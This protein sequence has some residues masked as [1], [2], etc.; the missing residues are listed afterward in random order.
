MTSPD[1]SQL[2]VQNSA[3]Q[4]S[5]DSASNSLP[6]QIAPRRY[7]RVPPDG[8]TPQTRVVV[9]CGWASGKLQYLQKYDTLYRER[10]F[11][12]FYILTDSGP[13]FNTS[14]TAKENVEFWDPIVEQITSLGI[15]C[16][17]ESPSTDIVLHAFSNGGVLQI[18]KL[19]LTLAQHEAKLGKFNISCMI[20]DSA[21]SIISAKT[22]LNFTTALM[23]G[24]TKPGTLLYRLK[25]FLGLLVFAGVL[26]PATLVI[27]IL[28][29]LGVDA[30]SFFERNDEVLYSERFRTIPRLF[31][32]SKGDRLVEYAAVEVHKKRSRECGARMV[33]DAVWEKGE[34]VKLQMVEPERYTRSVLSF[35]SE[36]ESLGR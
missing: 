21:P 18:W 28:R 4:N 25:S 17:G 32:H 30:A 16:F 33:R 22:G 15:D 2:A 13:V 23:T 3:L 6:T 7:V 20:L 26:F 9:L 11:V 19:Y 27:S 24:S 10:G 5:V 36:V 1:D 31:L 12:I 14:K 8:V 34:H 29:S 35:F